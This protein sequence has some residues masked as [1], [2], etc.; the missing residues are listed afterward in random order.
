MRKCLIYAVHMN[1]TNSG[2]KENIFTTAYRVLWRGWIFVFIL[3][4]LNLVSLFQHHGQGPIGFLLGIVLL[5]PIA[6]AIERGNP[7]PSNLGLSDEKTSRFN[8]SFCAGIIIIAW[9]SLYY[10]HVQAGIP[11]ILGAELAVFLAYVVRPRLKSNS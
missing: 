7:K 10:S 2:Q 9:Y 1:K 8:Y 4:S 11:A 6:V 3:F 5:F